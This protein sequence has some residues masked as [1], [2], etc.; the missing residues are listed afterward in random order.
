GG[1]NPFITAIDGFTILRSDYA[2][3]PAHRVFKPALCIT[4]QGAKWAK[5]G[6][7]RYDY[8]VGKALLVTVE[9]PS[10]GAVSVASPTK[11]F[12]GLVVELDKAIM[13]QVLEQLPFADLPVSNGG[14][15]GVCVMDMTVQLVDCVYRSVRLLQT[16]EAIPILYPGIMREICY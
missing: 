9:M 7:K 1:S 4:V 11:P 12:L 6:E 14:T 2:K 16:P 5:F 15:P 3:Q 8:R 10:R 13:Q